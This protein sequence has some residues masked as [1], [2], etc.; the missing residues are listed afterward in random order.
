MRKK[1][2]FDKEVRHLIREVE[3]LDVNSNNYL[4]ENTYFLKDGCVVC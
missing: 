1:Y 3:K 2:D 4:L